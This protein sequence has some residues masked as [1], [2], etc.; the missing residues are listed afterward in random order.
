MTECPECGSTNI[1]TTVTEG[2]Y[3]IYIRVYCL[4]CYKIIS[5]TS[6]PINKE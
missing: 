1:E 2:N 3:C 5:E 6:E 4:E